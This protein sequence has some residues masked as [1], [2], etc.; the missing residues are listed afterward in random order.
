MKKFLFVMCFSPLVMF[1]QS[2]DISK[3]QAYQLFLKSESRKILELK[4]KDFERIFKI[5]KCIKKN[6]DIKFKEMN[7]FMVKDLKDELATEKEYLMSG[8]ALSST[9]F[10]NY[11]DDGITKT[12]TCGVIKTFNVK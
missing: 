4:E 11:H 1:S 2:D 7:L 12:E 5:A 3:K 10:P 9:S 8:F 6:Y